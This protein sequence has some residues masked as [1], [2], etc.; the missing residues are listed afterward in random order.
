MACKHVEGKE[1]KWKK[2]RVKKARGKG[3][4]KREGERDNDG[5][6]IEKAERRKEKIQNEEG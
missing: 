6:K 2:R 5:E 3:K 1:S 4:S